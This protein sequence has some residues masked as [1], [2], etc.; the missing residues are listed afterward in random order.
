MTRYALLLALP[1][2]ALSSGPARAAAGYDACT[3]FITTV[4]TTITSQ[5]TWCLKAD[6]ATNVTSGAAIT[7]ANN[8]VTIDCN[9][10]K[11]GG[12][13]AGPATM[14]VGIQSQNR[15]NTTVRNCNVRGFLAGIL[16]D[17]NGSGHL[18]ENNRLDGNTFGGIVVQGD[19]AQVRG[20][21][22]FDTGWGSL[23]AHAAA[24]GVTGG[25][26]DVQDNVVYNVQ[27]TVGD[28]GDAYGVLVQGLS[29]GRISGNNVRYL[30]PDTGGTGYGVKLDGNLHVAVHD[31]HVANDDTGTGIACEAGS[32]IVRDNYLQGLD[33]AVEATCQDEGGN[34]TD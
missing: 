32:A 11:V 13:S 1:L 19:G 5:G 16:I 15:I 9:D 10:F 34:V 25:S 31:N 4:P 29:F 26:V 27:A 2:A 14:T 20:N 12:L 33:E 7:V 8:N 21:R 23:P 6:V 18:V 30:V 24:I 28:G 17:G 22:V 3:G